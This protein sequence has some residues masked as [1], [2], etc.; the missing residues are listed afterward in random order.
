M[1]IRF[2]FQIAVIS[3]MIACSCSSDKNTDEISTVKNPVDKTTEGT[4]EVP[5]SG[6]SITLGAE[7]PDIINP[8]FSDSVSGAYLSKFIHGYLL[9]LDNRM[10]TVAGLCD[11]VPGVSN[12]LVSENGLEYTFRL[13][14]NLTWHDG[15]P[16]T[17]EDIKFTHDIVKTMH[18]QKHVV[19]LEEYSHIETTEII[20]E[21]EIRFTLSSR[22]PTFLNIFIIHPVLP[23]HILYKAQSADLPVYNKKPVGAGPYKIESWERGK[24]LILKAFDNYHNGRPYI[25]RIT[26]NFFK[27]DTEASESLNK[28]IIDGFAGTTGAGDRFAA[29]LHPEI[30]SYKTISFDWE[31]LGINCDNPILK[32]TAVRQAISSAIDRKSILQQCFNGSGEVAVSDVPSITDAALLNLEENVFFDPQKSREFLENEGWTDSDGDGIRDNGSQR[33]EFDL[34]FDENNVQRLKSAEMISGCLSEV[35][36]KIKIRKL[37]SEKILDSFTRGGAL[38][39]GDYHFALYGWSLPFEPG[40][41]DLWMSDK[42][43]PS[44]KNY[45][46]FKNVAMDNLFT[47]LG[48]TYR[49]ENRKEVFYR[50]QQMLADELPVIPLVFLNRTDF[51]KKQLAGIKPHPIKWMT[52]WNVEK[53]WLSKAAQREKGNTDEVN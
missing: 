17:S 49:E 41:S 21:R 25:D 32:N 27:N 37:S 12:G 42:V 22:C 38:E 34:I 14:E 9:N 50:I 1:K 4:P 6:G 15:E 43:P 28:G 23:K 29:A 31:V 48:S 3:V 24:Q 26:F 47:E 40:N 11:E 46:R 18:I 10:K 45:S 39:K 35:G 53:W 20:N 19:Y 52:P 36:I 7:Y 33:M 5:V 8:V 2:L 51:Y 30:I 16:I 44:G 13:R